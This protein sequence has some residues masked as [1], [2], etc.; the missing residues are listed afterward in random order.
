MRHFIFPGLLAILLAVGLLLLLTSPEPE[1]MGPPRLPISATSD[2]ITP[3]PLPSDPGP[4]LDGGAGA[5]TPA[6]VESRPLDP[7]PA[8][9]AE[10]PEAAAEAMAPAPRRPKPKP[11]VVTAQPATEDPG[12]EADPGITPQAAAAGTETLA[13][14]AS[15]ARSVADGDVPANGLTEDAPGAE[16]G[17]TAAGIEQTPA[18]PRADPNPDAAVVATEIPPAPDPAE[19]AAADPEDEAGPRAAPPAPLPSLEILLTPDGYDR[20]ALTRLV[21]ESP[22][23]AAQKA[24]LSQAIAAANDPSA[25]SRLVEQ[26]RALLGL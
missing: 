20:A 13:P 3:A 23:G 4:R 11:P 10:A 17:A 22:L 15:G 24:A 5:T 9:T 26:L 25:Q 12:A 7:A 18:E 6:P 8:P 21:A 14:E 1:T 2:P 19:A 16:A